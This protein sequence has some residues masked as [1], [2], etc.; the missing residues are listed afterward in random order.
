MGSG[1]QISCSDPLCVSRLFWTRNKNKEIGK[2]SMKKDL[3]LIRHAVQCKHSEDV[4]PLHATSSFELPILI[5]KE[6]YM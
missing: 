5:G 4:Q 1:W 2:N 3:K 6:D